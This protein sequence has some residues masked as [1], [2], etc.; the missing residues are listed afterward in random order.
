MKKLK[1]AALVI[2]ASAV[3]T[4]AAPAATF[5]QQAAPAAAPAVRPQH[6]VR[7]YPYKEVEASYDNKARPGV[8]LAGTL[9]VPQGKGPFPAVLLI[10]GSGPQDRDETIFGHK[11]FLVLSD[12]LTRRGIA[13]L[14]VDDRGIGGSTGAG[15]ND[16]SNDFATDVQAGIDW[17]KTR[18]E[19]DAS[20]I[21]LVGHSEGGL[22]APIVAKDNPDVAFAVL[23]AGTG[24]SGAD[25]IV[26]QV[27]AVTAST[28]ASAEAVTA[29]ANQQKALVDAILAAP[30]QDTAYQSALQ[31]VTAAGQTEEQA[32]PGIKFLTGAWFRNFLVYDPAPTLKALD[33]PVLA[34]LG[35][36]DV[37]VLASQNGPAMKAAFA[38]NPRAKVIELP[39]LNHLFQNATSGSPM[40]YGTITETMDPAALKLMGDWIV[41]VTGAGANA[42]Q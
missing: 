9:T 20:R 29:A 42:G 36:K 4:V 17:L 38:G 27:R 30:D 41:E 25:V 3:A 33:I 13:V 7:P 26:E 34:L 28:G 16:T 2:S 12:H 37:Q 22:I 32:G 19:V 14:R 18:P 31:I 23:W 39:N 24:V 6:P 5:A 1:I 15:P 8:H 11:P 35:G 21:G 10:T 40:E